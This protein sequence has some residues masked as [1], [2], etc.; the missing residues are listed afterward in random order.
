MDTVFFAFA[1]SVAL[2]SI[3]VFASYIYKEYN[4][5][6]IVPQNARWFLCHSVGNMAITYLTWRD[7][8]ACLSISDTC[9]ENISQSTWLGL[10][11]SLI[12]H[13]YHALFFKLTRSDII[14]HSVMCC[15]S[16]PL[17]LLYPSK[18][19][20]G[21]LFF[22]TGLPGAIDYFLLWLVKMKMIPNMVEKYIYVLIS[23]WL[24][25]PGCILCVS[26]WKLIMDHSMSMN[27]QVSNAILLI[28]LYWNGQYYMMKTCIDYGRKINM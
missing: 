20:S 14:H 3:D 24:R 25:S 9:I 11:L 8:F 22:L 4:S 18:M 19:I 16:G 10:V 13:L 23:T 17:A 12:L 26:N 5:E 1:T 21:G 15:I 7:T 28:L 2:Y 6:C 27:E